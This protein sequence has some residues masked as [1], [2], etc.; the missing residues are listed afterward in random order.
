MTPA[1][2]QIAS[3]ALRLDPADRAE[4]A[5]RLLRSFDSAREDEIS[6]TQDDEDFRAAL[7]RT[8]RKYSGALKK[9]AE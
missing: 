6:D 9:L 4:I 3:Q 5:D 2:E 8:N 7:D 1:A